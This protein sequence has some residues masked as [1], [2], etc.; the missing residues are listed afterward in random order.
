MIA[1]NIQ[2][3]LEAAPDAPGAEEWILKNKPEFKKRYGQNWARILYA[4]AWV[5]F[6][7]H[8]KNADAD[9]TAKVVHEASHITLLVTDAGGDGAT[10]VTQQTLSGGN[11]DVQI[12]R[13]PE[14]SITD[15]ET[16]PRGDAPAKTES[17]KGGKLVAVYP[18]QIQVYEAAEIELGL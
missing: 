16:K 18:A 2:Q 17:Q 4:K 6:G 5:I 7:K 8:A 9:A 12:D 14:T 3:L 13:R 11:M 1:A 10:Q 15:P